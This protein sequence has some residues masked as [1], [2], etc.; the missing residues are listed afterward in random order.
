MQQQQL[1]QQQMM[2]QQLQQ[3][4]LQQQLQE[5]MQLQ[6]QQLKAG[7]THTSTA[8]D[9][10]LVDTERAKQAE[11]RL[12]ATEAEL[13]KANTRMNTIVGGLQKM[14]ASLQEEEEEEDEEEQEGDSTT[15]DPPPKGGNKP[16]PTDVEFV[17]P[18]P[19]APSGGDPS[20]PVPAIPD[21]FDLRPC[22]ACHQVSYNRKDLCVNSRCE[23]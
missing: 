20:D 23:P 17:D 4:Q 11:S 10:V 2:Q 5:Q 14:M 1:Q 6:L 12:R 19:A 21:Y 22:R 15:I 8:S 13:A 7:Q 3:Q 16:P 9:A 18:E